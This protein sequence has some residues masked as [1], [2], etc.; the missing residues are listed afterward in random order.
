M[1]RASTISV[2]RVPNRRRMLLRG[3]G[4]RRAA[5]LY[6]SKATT[7]RKTSTHNVATIRA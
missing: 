4:Y 1:S 7:Q 2:T 3:G 6:A 5:V